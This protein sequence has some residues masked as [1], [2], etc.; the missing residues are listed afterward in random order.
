MSALSIEREPSSGVTH[1]KG[2]VEIKMGAGPGLMTILR[3]DEV[4]YNPDTGDIDTRGNLTIC[5][6]GTTGPC[7]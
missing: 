5:T 4:T 7:S 2:A 3:A 6:T 1:L